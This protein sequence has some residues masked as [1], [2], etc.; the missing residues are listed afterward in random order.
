MH[1]RERELR[2]F[3]DLAVRAPVDDDAADVPVVEA[4]VLRLSHSEVGLDPF[5][6]GGVLHQTP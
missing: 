5:N 1:M 2:I 6:S 4:A 3:R